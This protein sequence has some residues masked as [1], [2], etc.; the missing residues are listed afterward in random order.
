[1]TNVL[2]QLHDQKDPFITK[3]D[4]SPSRGTGPHRSRL[5]RGCGDQHETE[6][7]VRDQGS[8]KKRKNVFCL[9]LFF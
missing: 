3:D 4:E 8:L 2:F 7:R 5:A 6:V 1:M 9:E